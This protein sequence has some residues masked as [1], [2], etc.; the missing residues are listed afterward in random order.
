MPQSKSKTTTNERDCYNDDKDYEMD[1]TLSELDRLREREMQRR[2][3]Q[4]ELKE[5]FQVKEKH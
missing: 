3:V 1:R 5:G 2:Q 4:V